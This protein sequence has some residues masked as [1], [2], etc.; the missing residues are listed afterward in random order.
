[1]FGF[2]IFDFSYVIEVSRDPR[3]SVWVVCDSMRASRDPNGCSR[4]FCGSK[5]VSRD[6]MG[7]AATMVLIM[8][9]S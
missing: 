3:G 8:S 2:V 6:P 9:V 1:M 4:F 5:V 7:P